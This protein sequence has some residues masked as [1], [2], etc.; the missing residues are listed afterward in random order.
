MENVKINRCADSDSFCEHGSRVLF[1]VRI[2][3]LQVLAFS[4]KHALANKMF[5]RALKFATK[6]V[7]DKPSKENWKNCVQVR[8]SERRQQSCFYSIKDA[9]KL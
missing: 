4:Y 2:S 3:S 7:E 9:V 1:D 5:A 8:V 6:I